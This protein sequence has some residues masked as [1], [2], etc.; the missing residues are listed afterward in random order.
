[1]TDNGEIEYADPGLIHLPDCEAKDCYCD[2]ITFPQEPRWLPG[3]TF[4]LT[5]SGSPAYGMSGT[6]TFKGLVMPPIPYK[7]FQ[8]VQWDNVD[9]EAMRFY[10]LEL[11][12]QNL[13][14]IDFV[15][16]MWV[17]Q[18][19]RLISLKEANHLLDA[20]VELI[21]QKLVLNALDKASQ[22][23]TWNGVRLA[24]M[25]KELLFG[26]MRVYRSDA[27]EIQHISDPELEISKLSNDILSSPR[28]S[29]LPVEANSE[30]TDQIYQ[31][32]LS[33]MA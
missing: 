17:D 6:P 27:K 21:N 5:V 26:D 11:F 9:H 24:R 12:I 14:N 28:L 2:Q 10:S 15:E 20:R 23:L 1:M 3:R 13:E 7:K 4:L 8:Q 30:L 33:T 25:A 32:V 19:D 22:D 18:K 29:R 16:M 31:S